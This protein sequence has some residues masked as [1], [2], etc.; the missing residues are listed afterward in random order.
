[1]NVRDTSSLFMFAQHSTALA[2][3]PWSFFLILYQTFDNCLTML[4]LNTSSASC[5]VKSSTVH[6]S[7]LP[8]F[9]VGQYCFHALWVRMFLQ[10]KSVSPLDTEGKARVRGS[11]V[12]ATGTV[13]GPV[14]SIVAHW[15]WEYWTR[16]ITH[17]SK[18]WIVSL[19]CV[20][21]WEFF[22]IS[23]LKLF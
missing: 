7:R 19:R 21:Q 20:D 4:K 10:W 17:E 18:S 9:C 3:G 8:P 14:A 12:G 23:S 16:E 13:C 11:I 15:S 1:M 6:K 2:V 5:G 22:F